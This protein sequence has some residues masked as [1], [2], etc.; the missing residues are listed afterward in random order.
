MAPELASR[1]AGEFVADIAAFVDSAEDAC[2]ARMPEDDKILE[3][4]LVAG[5]REV[6]PELFTDV[7]G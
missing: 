6:V 2:R 4:G 3:D 7:V 1:F 5:T